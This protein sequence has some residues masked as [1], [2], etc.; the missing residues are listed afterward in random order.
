MPEMS[1][2]SPAGGSP[3]AVPINTEPEPTLSMAPN[4]SM[5]DFGLPTEC[6]ETMRCPVLPNRTGGSDA[7]G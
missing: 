7:F 6:H 2:L 3:W 4:S 5:T 1:S